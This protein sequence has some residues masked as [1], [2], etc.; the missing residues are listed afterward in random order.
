MVSLGTGFGRHRHNSEARFPARL[1]QAACKQ[2]GQRQEVHEGGEIFR[3]DLEFDGEQPSLDDVSHM[4]ETA[5]LAREATLKSGAMQQLAR[6]F[7]AELFLFELDPAQPPRYVNGAY[8]CVGHISCRLRAG[9]EEFR[10]F[11]E[12][13]HQSGAFFRCHDRDLPSTFPNRDIVKRDGNFCQEVTLHIPS[14]Q[15]VFEI[16]LCE[17]TTCEASGA[18]DTACNIGGSPFTVDWL[19]RQQGLEMWFGAAGGDDD[20]RR[21]RLDVAAP[22][23]AKRRKLSRDV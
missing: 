19:S 6:R 8:D 18:P 9:T 2:I 14:R 22:P 5:R 4:G 23:R 3:F 7:R 11:M 20:H 13:L 16:T 15:D 1:Y 10:A 17:A 21:P 12:Q